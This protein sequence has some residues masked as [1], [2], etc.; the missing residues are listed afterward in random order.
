[1]IHLSLSSSAFNGSERL[2]GTGVHKG[3]DNVLI[4]GKKGKKSWLHHFCKVAQI[5]VPHSFMC[6][7]NR[8]RKKIK[9]INEKKEKKKKKTNG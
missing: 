7:E 6:N 1:M 4:K 9:K 2:G 5:P 8:A 3:E